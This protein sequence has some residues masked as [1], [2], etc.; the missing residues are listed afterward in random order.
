MEPGPSPAPSQMGVSGASRC[1]SQAFERQSLK[2]LLTFLFKIIYLFIYFWLCWV[3]VAARVF[4]SCGA[5]ASHCSEFSCCRAP[6]SR[7]HGLQQLQLPGSGAQN[8]I[9]VALRLSCS[10][11]CGVF[12]DQG[13]NTCFLPWQENS[14]PAELPGKPKVC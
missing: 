2:D 13:L 9:V 10:E 6:G 3:F 4:S 7:A 8:L 11:A 14:L 1:W 5:R 12:L